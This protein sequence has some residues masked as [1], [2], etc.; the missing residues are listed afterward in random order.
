[1]KGA[2]A[3]NPVPARVEE[4]KAPKHSVYREGSSR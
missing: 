2:D 3:Q 1:M 4:A